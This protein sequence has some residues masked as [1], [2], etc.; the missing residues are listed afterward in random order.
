MNGEP[1]LMS[2]KNLRRISGTMELLM[3]TGFSLFGG[4][5]LKLY[6]DKACNFVTNLR[7][8]EET[9]LCGGLCIFL[10]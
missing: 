4:R 9:I 10:G 6:E 2:L 3:A 1:T 8:K 7:G 5:V